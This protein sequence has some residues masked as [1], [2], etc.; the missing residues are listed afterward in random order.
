[1]EEKKIQAVRE[2]QREDAELKKQEAELK[3]DKLRM[4][5]EARERRDLLNAL[6][7]EK[8]G[9]NE[10]KIMELMKMV[11]EQIMAEY[12]SDEETE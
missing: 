12:K 1:V 10:E 7:L 6:A 2:K 11:H 3:K 8:L 9:N 5:K 4:R